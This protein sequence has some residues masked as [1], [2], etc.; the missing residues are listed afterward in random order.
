MFCEKCGSSMPDGSKF[1]TVC[2]AKLSR[3]H[4]VAPRKSRKGGLVALIVAL[5]LLLAGALGLLVYSLFLE[6]PVEISASHSSQQDEDPPDLTDGSTAPDPTDGSTASGEVTQTPQTEPEPTTPSPTTEELA[7]QLLQGMTTEQQVYQLFV[8]TPEALTGEEACLIPG[9]GLTD[10]LASMPVG[11]VILAE[12]NILTPEQC[13]D[14][15]EAMQNA[16]G[17]P[18]FIAVNEEGGKYTEISCNST[19]G[20]EQIPLAKDLGDSTAAYDRNRSLAEA[21]RALGFNLNLSPVSDVNSNAGNIVI[22]ERA[23]G[24]DPEQVAELAVSAANGLSEGGVIPCMK[25]YPGHGDVDTDALSY[26]SAYKSL[27]QLLETELVPFQAGI[28]AGLP[29]IMAGYIACP[30]VTGD[31]LPAPLSHALIQE[32]LRTDLGFRGVVMTDVLL[33]EDI[34]RLYPDGQAAVMALEAGCDLL[35]MPKDLETTAQA[36]LAALETG[37]L[38]RQRLEESVLRVL[39]LK[40]EYGII[41]TP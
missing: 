24:S 40:L 39:E 9:A 22:G 30:N 38:E 2:G 29:M 10:A 11:G 14:L 1:C 6:E 7:R 3:Q 19:M 32:L 12:R 33:R 36:I 35:L 16:S 21:I 20:V 18:M 27:D 8:V 26:A 13:K 37:E 5:S 23:F 31:E 4:P 34:N 41:P 17:I 15:I 28:D 25:H